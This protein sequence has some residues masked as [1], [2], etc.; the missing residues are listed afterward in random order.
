M[1]RRHHSRSGHIQSFLE[2]FGFFGKGL[3]RFFKSELYIFFDKFYKKIFGK[4]IKRFDKLYFIIY[5]NIQQTLFKKNNKLN[6][7]S[8]FFKSH[9]ILA[10]WDIFPSQTP[11]SYFSFDLRIKPT[12]TAE[13][14]R[15]ITFEIS[16]L[17]YS[18]R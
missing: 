18:N 7:K 10:F 15:K 16:Y 1:F 9:G 5:K 8:I 11:F 12:K 13:S 14:W 6:Q 2:K 17:E 4:K 3:S